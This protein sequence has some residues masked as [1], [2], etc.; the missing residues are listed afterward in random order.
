MHFTRIMDLK[1]L[2][3]SCFL[4]G[5]RMTGKTY[6]LKGLKSALHF[7]LLDP[8]LELEWKRKPGHFWESLGRCSPADLIVID[9]IQKVPVLLNY[10]QKGIEELHLRFVLS[11]SSARKLKRGMAN[12]LGGRAL[13]LKLFPLTC[14]E[15][16]EDVDIRDVCHYGT[17]PKIAEL[18]VTNKRDDIIPIL[19]SYYSIYI[20]EEVQSEAITRNIGAFQRFLQISAQTNAQIISYSN[21][22]RES[23]VPQ[24]TVKEYFQILE[25]TLLGTFLWQWDKSERKKTHPK[26]YFFDCGVVR[27]IQNRLIDPPTSQEYGFLFETYFFHELQ[28]LSHY[29]QKFF[30]FSYWKKRNHEV[31]FI[32]SRGGKIFCGIECKSSRTDISGNTIDLFQK[33]FPGIPLYIAS[34]DTLPTRKVRDAVEVLPWRDVLAIVKQL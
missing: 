1:A 19:R 6:L 21:I 4:L 8:E 16:G 28:S 33:D 22:S 11:G 25:D 20:K 12:L 9:E 3:S 34:A 29:E 13:D 30:E 17:L 27:A 14:Y 7:D 31:D 23:A 2:N 18:L 10:V 26:F 32:V 24:S 5:P 15:Y